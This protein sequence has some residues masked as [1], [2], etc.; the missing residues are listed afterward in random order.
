[1]LK[2]VLVTIGLFVSLLAARPVY[3][4][5]LVIE[6]V[7]RNREFFAGFTGYEGCYLYDVARIGDGRIG[8]V[9]LSPLGFEIRLVLEIQTGETVYKDIFV[10]EKGKR[11]A[12]KRESISVADAVRLAK[13]VIV[14][15]R[16]NRT[17]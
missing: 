15:E 3:A 7:A 11:E 8:L 9:L 17:Y 2:R 4:L 5:P 13:D 14:R 16:R 1:M 6:D 10:P 12:M